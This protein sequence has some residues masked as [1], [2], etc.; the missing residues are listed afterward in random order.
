MYIYI[1]F[2]DY[3]YYNVLYTYIHHTVSDMICLVDVEHMSMSTIYHIGCSKR[4]METQSHVAVW[5]SAS[6]PSRMLTV[7]GP[8]G[9]KTQPQPSLSSQEREDSSRSLWSA[10]QRQWR[11]LGSCDRAN[12]ESSDD[13]E[14]HQVLFSRNL[15]GSVWRCTRWVYNSLFQH[16]HVYIFI[17]LYYIYMCIHV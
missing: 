3:L 7:C 5:W 6:H 17:Y 14:V 10:L 1:C 4:V 8:W 9:I 15:A 16:Q 12:Q 11:I 13:D 2:T